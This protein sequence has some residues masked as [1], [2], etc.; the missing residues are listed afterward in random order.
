MNYST[1][2][3]KMVDSGNFGVIKS[4]YLAIRPNGRYA[5]WPGKEYDDKHKAQKFVPVAERVRL[6][7]HKKKEA[8]VMTKADLK[9]KERELEKLVSNAHRKMTKE[10]IDALP[11]LPKEG[12]PP[13]PPPPSSP[14]R[15]E[16]CPIEEDGQPF[17]QAVPDENQDSYASE[18]DEYMVKE[19]DVHHDKL[20]RPEHIKR[21]KHKYPCKPFASLEEM[22]EL[23]KIIAP[24]CH[25]DNVKAYTMIQAHKV[26]RLYVDILFSP[27]ILIECFSGVSI[28][29]GT[30]ICLFPR[31]RMRFLRIRRMTTSS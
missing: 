16:R 25:K 24:I 3:K 13:P 17:W 27:P 23:D 10:E 21:N 2:L 26:F 15:V 12:D 6:S 4:M 31:T 29:N 19:E 8:P 9:K 18:S 11:H 28:F 5:T 7:R 22:Q 30:R 1:Q 20:I 14:P